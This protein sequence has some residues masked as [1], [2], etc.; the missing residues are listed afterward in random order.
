[1]DQRHTA[2]FHERSLTRVF[3]AQEIVLSLKTFFQASMLFE[4]IETKE[5]DV[6]QD[7]KNILLV[8][9]RLNMCLLRNQS[10]YH[11]KSSQAAVKCKR[12]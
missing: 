5:Q 9:V 2:I 6:A 7:N 1:M 12:K 3:K 4:I 10:Q 8:S 11:C